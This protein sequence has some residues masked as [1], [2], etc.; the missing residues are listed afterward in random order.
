MDKYIEAAI[1]ESVQAGQ[2]DFYAT[3]KEIQKL[4]I[5]L[6]LEKFNFN[7]AQ[8]ARH[9]KMNRTSLVQKLEPF[10]MGHLIKEATP[11]KREF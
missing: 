4:I 9:L 5:T 10:G 3:M 7:K 11:A 8:A 1:R 2:I 6:A